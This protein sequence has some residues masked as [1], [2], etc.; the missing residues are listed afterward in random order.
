MN[1]TVKID[2][3]QAFKAKLDELRRYI[4][5]ADAWKQQGERLFAQGDGRPALRTPRDAVELA[6][7]VDEWW[8]DRP[9]RTV[10]RQ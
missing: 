2:D 3:P 6:F 5:R 10:A 1:M 9:R 7:A 8:A 4:K